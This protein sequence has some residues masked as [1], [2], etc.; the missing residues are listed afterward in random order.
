M[1]YRPPKVTETWYD[2]KENV[3]ELA[4]FLVGTEQIVSSEDLLDL[5]ENPERYTS[6]WNLYQKEILGQVGPP[7]NGL[8]IITPTRMPPHDNVLPIFAALATIPS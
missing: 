4:E 5:F 2:N 7:L 3:A 1:V 6:V 8:V